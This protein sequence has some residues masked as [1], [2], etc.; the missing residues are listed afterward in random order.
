MNDFNCLI[1]LLWLEYQLIIC[2]LWH[3]CLHHDRLDLCW[4]FQTEANFNPTK[5]FH[6]FS[7]S[8]SLIVQWR[9]ADN[10]QRHPVWILKII[11]N[12]RLPSVLLD[13]DE[14]KERGSTGAEQSCVSTTFCHN[15]WHW[16]HYWHWWQWTLYSQSQCWDLHQQSTAVKK[17]GS[18]RISSDQPMWRLSWFVERDKEYDYDYVTHSTCFPSGFNH[19]KKRRRGVDCGLEEVGRR[20]TF[21][22]LKLIRMTL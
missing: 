9:N 12:N 4:F 11:A 15:C 20:R 3:I 21:E 10:P 1:C 8:W 5:I 14:D 18:H 19:N 6:L 13:L 17:L 2:H 22:L 16:W 7:W